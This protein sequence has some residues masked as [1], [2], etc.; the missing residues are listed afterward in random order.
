MYMYL[1]SA[2]IVTT[3]LLHLDL[4]P[5][6]LSRYTLVP[7]RVLSIDYRPDSSG[8]ISVQGN[9]LLPFIT[10]DYLILGG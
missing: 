1:L 4:V 10:L 5:A 8:R 7:A 3:S 6:A 9:W 2:L